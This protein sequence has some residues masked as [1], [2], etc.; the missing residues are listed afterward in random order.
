MIPKRAAARHCLPAY[1][2][3]SPPGFCASD[4]AVFCGECRY[5][6][7]IGSTPQ[8]RSRRVR[9]ALL[10]HSRLPNPQACTPK[11]TALDIYPH[12]HTSGAALLHPPPDN[13]A[14]LELD[15]DSSLQRRRPRTP[16]RLSPIPH[17][18]SPS[19]SHPT[20]R[21]WYVHIRE[22]NTRLPPPDRC[23]PAPVLNALPLST[24]AR[25]PTFTR[26]S[27]AA[28]DTLECITTRPADTSRPSTSTTISQTS[29]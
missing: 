8:P 17:V 5:A 23:M 13:T 29:L 24:C 21:V 19:L 3:K 22:H 27:W 12:Q 15:F 11:Q 28:A 25:F 26:S 10:A 20:K 7:F 9:R 1:P 18:I 16:R 2:T 6:F 4:V 14:P